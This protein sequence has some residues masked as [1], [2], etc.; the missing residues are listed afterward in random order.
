MIFGILIGFVVGL[1]LAAA[2]VY[3]LILWL[4]HECTRG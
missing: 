4:A 2:V 3:A 1:V